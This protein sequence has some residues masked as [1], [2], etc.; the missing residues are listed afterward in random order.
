[1]KVVRSPLVRSPAGS[2]LDTARRPL[3]TVAVTVYVALSKGWW[4][5]GNH[6]IEPVGWPS[7]TAPSAVR[8]Q[9][10][11]EPSGSVTVTGA[12]E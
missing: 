9:P 11:S 3:G 1:M 2:P 5:P 10:S 6:A 8:S 4:L 12:P 7:A